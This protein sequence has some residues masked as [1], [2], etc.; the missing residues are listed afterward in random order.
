LF[1][2]VRGKGKGK[3]RGGYRAAGGKEKLP[4]KRGLGG[5]KRNKIYPGRRNKQEEERSL[6]RGILSIGRQF[7]AR[8]V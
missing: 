1:A 3:R 6:G 5:R 7:R 8:K 2:D 4:R